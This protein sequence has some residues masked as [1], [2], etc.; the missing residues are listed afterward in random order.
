MLSM[1]FDPAAIVLSAKS[2]LNPPDWVVLLPDHAH[3]RQQRFE[4]AVGRPGVVVY[5]V[6]WLILLPITGVI[7]Q[8]IA[9]PLLVGALYLLGF[10]TA[11]AGLFGVFWAIPRSLARH[12]RHALILTPGGL[13][14]A[15]WTTG[16]VIKPLEYQVTDELKLKWNA[17]DDATPGSYYLLITRH[18]KTTRWRVGDYFTKRPDEIARTIM[19]DYARAKGQGGA[20]E[21][22]ARAG[23]PLRTL[24]GTR[25]SLRVRQ[26]PKLPRD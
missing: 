13:V 11:L 17:P 2:G 16:E 10:T 20:R 3:V 24:E 7:P 23:G 9:N 15:D 14:L 1:Q 25:R 18:G 19:R 26:N 5:A 8:L 12:S 4:L 6:I 21:A 22:S